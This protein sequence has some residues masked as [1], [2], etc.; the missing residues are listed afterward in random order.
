MNGVLAATANDRSNDYVVV[1][2]NEPGRA[3]VKPGENI[4]AVHVH[5]TEGTQL[6]DIGIVVPRGM[7]R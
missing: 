4:L 1:P 3:A 6:I 5:H 7:W 2:M